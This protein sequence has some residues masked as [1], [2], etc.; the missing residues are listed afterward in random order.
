MAR[1]RWWTGPAALLLTL[2]LSA[3][4]PASPVGQITELATTTLS[5]GPEGIVAGPDGNLWFAEATA[6]KIAEVDPSTGAIAEFPTPTGGSL[7]LGITMGADGRLWFT[8]FAAGKVGVIDPATGVITEF[9][10]PTAA[11]DPVGIAAGPNGDVWFTEDAADKVAEINPITDAITELKVPTAAGGPFGIVAGPDGD[12]WFT[13]KTASK[14]GVIDPLTMAIDEIPTTTASAMPN[15]IAAG[16]D[17]SMWFTEQAG[18]ASR[19]GLVDVPTRKLTEFPTPTA[20]SGP[21]VIEPGADGDMWFT[22]ANASKVAAINPVTHAITEFATPT[23]SAGPIGVAAG[24]DGD[25]WFTENPAAKVGSVGTGAPPASAAAPS[26]AGTPQPGG[27]LTCQGALWSAWA[28]QQPALTAI[29]ADGVR[30]L[31]DG[32]PIAGAVASAYVVGAGDVGH[33]LACQVTVTYPL[34]ATTTSASSAPVT[35]SPPLAA[36]L[37]SV[38]TLGATATLTMSCQGLPTQSCTGLIALRSSVTTR[39]GKITASSAKAKPKK[40]KPKVIRRETVASGSYSVAAGHSATVKLAL[41]SAGVK[42]LDRLYRVPSTMAIT[43]TGSFTRR[44]TFSYGRLHAH[45]EA[46]WSVAKHY[47]VA[48]RL[49]LTALP[50]PAVVTVI[51]RGDGC[52]FSRRSFAPKHSTLALATALHMRHLSP[53]AT[54]ELEVTEPNDVGQIIVYTINSGRRPTKALRCLPPGT[55]T[56]TACA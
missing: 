38:S 13:E 23:P 11:S 30:W 49:T 10:I 15:A 19:I 37:S 31:R 12:V 54:V 47:S 25:M 48:T 32:S 29:A 20:A 42:V 52:P 39:A 26:I 40:A 21:T 35:P 4:A 27:Q 53:H 16:P 50:S 46:T 28:G 55:R 34:L 1:V 41:D 33:A 9:P 3:D 45:A 7:P 43:G 56:V 2:V 5:S 44:V 51:C 6:S 14:I 22:E 17:D 24:A 36:T 18:A 8:E